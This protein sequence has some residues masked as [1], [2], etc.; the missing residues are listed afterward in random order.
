[1]E[2]C[3]ECKFMVYTALDNNENPDSSEKY[4]L[5]NYCKN[6]GWKDNADI[7]EK[8]CVYK[9]N[10]EN[11][12]LADKILKNK[13]TIFD[14]SL[15]RLAYDCIND[16]CITNIELKSENCIMIDNIP[17]EYDMRSIE[18]L[19]ESIKSNVE[20]MTRVR[21]TS[22]VI[23]LK[24]SDMSDKDSI[25]TNI[26]KISSPELADKLIVN[27]FIMP[28]KEVIYMKYNPE[29]MKYIYMCCNCGTSWQGGTD[30]FSFLG[31]IQKT[32]QDIQEVVRK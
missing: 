19:L 1:M 32:E 17:E 3:P 5:K 16:N 8:T 21:L 20:K 28:N 11:E 18:K 22:L 29:D 26:N 30:K 24:E 4:I 25:I 31:D 27:D 6:C 14:N 9:R 12:F 23:E 10:Y 13:Y 2:F 7:S 15:P